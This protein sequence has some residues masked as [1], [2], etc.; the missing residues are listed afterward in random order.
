M[1]IVCLINTCC[2][3][4]KDWMGNKL[5]IC[6]ILYCVNDL[7]WIW[8]SMTYVFK[9]V[10]LLVYFFIT[11]IM[12]LLLI[13]VRLWC[14]LLLL[15]FILSAAMIRRCLLDPLLT[16]EGELLSP[17]LLQI[18]VFSDVFLFKYW[19]SLLYR[20]FYYWTF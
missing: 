13:L 9:Y 18:V 7:W 11:V 2:W 19:D 14:L 8:W 15:H 4:M 12:C 17:E 1:K 6:L 16:Y 5:C 10:E 3:I 20:Y